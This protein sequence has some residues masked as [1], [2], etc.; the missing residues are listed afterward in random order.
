LTGSK[1]KIKKTAW[2]RGT[3]EI[4][5][6]PVI[7]CLKDIQDNFVKSIPHDDTFLIKG[8]KLAFD[9]ETDGDDVGVFLV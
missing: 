7:I 2:E 1:E 4:R 9:K 8:K 3:D 6:K 5:S